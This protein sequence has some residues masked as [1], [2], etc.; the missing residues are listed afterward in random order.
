MCT[1][2][3]KQLTFFIIL[4]DEGHLRVKVRA[5]PS[6]SDTTVSATL[7]DG[8]VKTKVRR[9]QACFLTKILV[10]QDVGPWNV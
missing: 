10:K 3:T 1:C 7:H 5:L 8:P 6:S 4:V 2:G 9:T